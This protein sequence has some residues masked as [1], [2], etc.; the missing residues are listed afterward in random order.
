MTLLEM[1]QKDGFTKYQTDKNSSHHYFT[2]YDPFFKPFQH[3]PVGVFEVGTNTGGSANLWDDYFDH[4]NTIIRSIDILD[5]P[6]SHRAYTN[7][8]KLDIV[9]INDLTPE[10]FKDFPVDIAI[11]DGSHTID[12]QAFFVKLLYP[13][14]RKGGIL[15]VEDVSSIEKLTAAIKGLCYPFFI[16]NFNPI[17]NWYDSVLFIF[18]K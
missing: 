2:I 12:D 8:V 15:I 4:P 14:V 6:E 7:R 17:D 10:Y 3:K 9:D 16:A 18:I 13:I 1:W 5:V 11:D